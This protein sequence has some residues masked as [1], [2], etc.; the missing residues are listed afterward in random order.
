MDYEA[1]V[2]GEDGT[3]AGVFPIYK[4]LIGADSLPFFSPAV[5]LIYLLAHGRCALPGIHTDDDVCFDCVYAGPN[6]WPTD[7]QVQY[8]LA[9]RGK[10][11]AGGGGGGGGSASGTTN[12]L[13]PGP[14][15]CST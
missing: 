2:V 13:N 4:R 11:G 14:P 3:A 15:Q 1:P 12:A 10:T 9:E 8:C 7:D 6:Q 5:Q